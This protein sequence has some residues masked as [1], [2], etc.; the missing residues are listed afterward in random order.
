MY[1][2][3]E[4]ENFLTLFVQ[5][6]LLLRNKMTS[7]VRNANKMAME[8]SYFLTDLSHFFAQFHN[9]Q[10]SC[11]YLPLFFSIFSFSCL[12]CESTTILFSFVSHLQHFIRQQINAPANSLAF[13]FLRKCIKMKFNRTK[14]N[15]KSRDITDWFPLN[16]LQMYFY[17]MSLLLR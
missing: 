9:K 7:L 10:Q 8:K 12:R 2:L 16:S 13:W 11:P 15:V 1:T 17:Q 6:F 5:H 3:S 14:I 4:I